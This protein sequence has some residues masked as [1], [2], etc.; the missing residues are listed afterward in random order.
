MPDFAPPP[1]PSDPALAYPAPT[2][3]QPPPA[4]QPPPG[5][6]PPPV[7]YPPGAPGYMP[8]PI[9][10]TAAAGMVGV[11]LLYQFGGYA[12]WSIGLGLVAIVVPFVS[13]YYFPVLPI[14]GVLN[15]IR[16]IQRGRVMGG[17]VGIGINAVAA[18]LTFM[19]WRLSS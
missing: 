11:G 8:P 10:P 9:A 16:A 13:N 2:A 15:A 17:I 12:A 4:N 18:L 14:V 7:A 19:L 1:P 3:Y 6:Q 5:Y